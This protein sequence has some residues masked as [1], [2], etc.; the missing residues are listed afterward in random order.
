MG[1]GAMAAA[2][3]LTDLQMKLEGVQEKLKVNPLD[4]KLISQEKKVKAQITAQTLVLQAAAG[5]G[6][7]PESPVP[8]VE[9]GAATPPAP[10]RL[11]PHAPGRGASAGAWRAR[12]VLAVGP[13]LSAA[14][15]DADADA[16]PD[17]ILID[18]TAGPQRASL[19]SI[20]DSVVAAFEQVC[21]GGDGPLAGQR[22]RGVVFEV[23]DV[24]VH[25]DGAHRSP[26]QIVPAAARAMRAAMLASGP[27]L[28]EPC[29]EA[30]VTVPRGAVRCVY[31][32]LR[33][34]DGVFGEHAGDATADEEY[35]CGGDRGGGGG[36]AGAGDTT[37]VVATLPIRAS[38]GL[39]QRLAGPTGGQALVCLAPAG[40]RA[41]EGSPYEEGTP[42]HRLVGDL[43]MRRGW[44]RQPPTAED[45]GDQL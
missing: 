20:R 7:M 10:A 21:G 32:E 31:D 18:A 12:D 14:E 16:G 42:A 26:A 11:Q 9:E 35:G 3:A 22:A 1:R 25:A 33:R 34:S 44:E 28:L 17:C 15:R 23:V 4:K 43:R 40:W 29:C 45:V 30:R 2:D 19:N 8:Q 5:G 38:F 36:D 27:A 41:V 39:T 37:T 13:V 6:S 24:K